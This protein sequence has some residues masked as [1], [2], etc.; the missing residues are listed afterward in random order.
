LHLQYFD[1]RRNSFFQWKIIQTH[2]RNINNDNEN[3]KIPVPIICFILTDLNLTISK[4]CKESTAN[5][6]TK[7]YK[8][9]IFSKKSFWFLS[10]D[11]FEWKV[12]YQPKT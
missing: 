1:P 3:P 10:Y 7:I 6:G 5:D 8:S 11:L 9:W 2:T 12:Y 4:I